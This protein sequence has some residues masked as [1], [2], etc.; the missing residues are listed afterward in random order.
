LAKYQD[1]IDPSLIIP[2]IHWDLSTHRIL[3]MEY[4]GGDVVKINQVPKLK[5]MNINLRKV[6]ERLTKAYSEMIFLTGF[7]HCDPHP[8]NILVRKNSRSSGGFDLIL[9]DHGLYKELSDEF[10]INYARLWKAVIDC[11]E[12][13]IAHLSSYFGNGEAH[14]LFSSMLTHRS[15]DRLTS[16]GNLGSAHTLA[17][18]QA[19]R[20]KAP[21]YLEKI[22]RVLSALPRDMLLLLKTNDLLRSIERKLSSESDWQ[23]SRSFLIMA[24]FCSQAILKDDLVHNKGLFVSYFRYLHQF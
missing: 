20:T 22:A 9:L 18:L 5:T 14:R 6:S 10:R 1:P 2:K 24:R 19:I 15:W 17:E 3:V 11:N 13:E 12:P 21:L 4:I 23:L 16:L 8:G 7:V